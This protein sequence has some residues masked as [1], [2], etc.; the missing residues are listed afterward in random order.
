MFKLFKFGKKKEEFRKYQRKINNLERL[1]R[2]FAAAKKTRL[3]DDWKITTESIN[4]EIF[5]S[6]DALRARS[7][8]LV[9]NNGYARKYVHMFKSGVIGPHGFTLQVKSRD[10]NGELDEEANDKIEAAWKK[11]TK[12]ENCTVRKNL[13]FFDVQNMFAETLPRDGE[14]LIRII[15]GFRNSFSFALQ[16]IDMDFLDVRYNDKLRNGNTVTMSIE[17]DEWSAPVAYHLLKR[18]PGS[19]Q[20]AVESDQERIRIPADQIIH[21]FIPSRASQTRGFPFMHASMINMNHVDAYQEGEL[22]ASRVAANKMGFFESESGEDYVADAVADDG[23]LI[24]QA[25]PGIFEQLP[26]GTKFTSFEPEHP[27]GNYDPFIKA[28]LRSIASGINVSYHSLAQDLESVN[29]SSLRAGTLEERDTWRSMHTFT[30]DHLLDRI[31]NEWVPFA[32]LTQDLNLPITKLEKFR[33]F[34]FQ[35]RSF[36]WVDP[37]KD[38]EA[39]ILEIQH[40]LKSRSDVM[41]E[42]GRDVKETFDKIA[43]EEQLAD[44]LDIDISTKQDSTGSGHEDEDED[45]NDNNNNEEE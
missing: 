26:A 15:R 29:F 18:H 5:G 19:F 33:S 12:P 34:W 31:Y 41:G 25:E 7:R 40:G 22:V 21:N 20:T 32:L 39:S 42:K 2:T 36:E 10:D 24:T 28:N 35:S 45:E 13:S 38:V 6:L 8:D 44:E 30:R 23:T 1:V 16:P 9:L 27:A 11:W 4:E 14:F 3:T 43:K 37:K 17:Y